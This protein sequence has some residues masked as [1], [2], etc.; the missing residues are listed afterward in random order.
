M[1]GLEGLERVKVENINPQVDC[2]VFPDGHFVMVLRNRP[3][4]LRDVVFTNQV[5]NRSINPDEDVGYG[6][7]VQAAIFTVVESLQ[8]QNLLLPDTSSSPIG[9]RTI[10]GCHVEAD[11]TKH[12]HSCEGGT[13]VHDAR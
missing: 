13:D 3:S 12:H 7:G 5:R 11:R 2:F 4:V 6:A 8:A 9:L 10:G 1:A